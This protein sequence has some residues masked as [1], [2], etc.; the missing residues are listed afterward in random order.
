GGV[1]IKAS[2]LRGVESEGMLCSPRELNLS[3]DAAGLLLLPP[4]APVGAPLSE[5]FP[6]DTVIEV[7]LTPN[8]PDL[9]SHYGIARELSALLD[10]PPAKLPEISTVSDQVR[11]DAGVVQLTA[12][13]GC[14]FYAA[15]FIRDS[16]V[17]PSPS[18]L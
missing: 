1:K 4:D 7:E 10:L 12:P 18:W 11:E 15:R 8:R 2:K 6:A 14:P 5:I 17:G 13:E 3:E 9:L 16:R